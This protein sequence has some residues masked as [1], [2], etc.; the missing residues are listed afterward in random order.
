MI[1]LQGA[2]C[3]KVP[4]IMS[5]VRGP[6][7]PGP[8]YSSLIRY[9]AG[10]HFTLILIGRVTTGS[11][12]P[13]KCC[14]M[15]LGYISVKG[16][17]TGL[18]GREPTFF[19][20]VFFSTLESGLA[21]HCELVLRVAGLV[22]AVEPSIRLG[23]AI[24]SAGLLG[25]ALSRQIRLVSLFA[26]VLSRRGFR[27][28]LRR[29]THRNGTHTH[30]YCPQAQYELRGWVRGLGDRAER[31]PSAALSSSNISSGAVSTRTSH[32]QLL[33]SK[34]ESS[35]GGLLSYPF[36]SGFLSLRLWGFQKT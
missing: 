5:P 22:R 30:T 33:I 28:F 19:T 26:E 16:V 20:F 11:Q 4:S 7:K 36:V 29:T 3:L 35:H 34:A 27:A 21:T 24:P 9:R 18:G 25:G 6:W 2:S 1:Y 12:R 31:F 15:N 17:L 8:A 14:D 13:P 23:R 10:C 32:S